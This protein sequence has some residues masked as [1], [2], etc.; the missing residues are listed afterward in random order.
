[1]GYNYNWQEKYVT[2]NILA[3]LQVVNQIWMELEH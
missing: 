3:L 1:M 2:A